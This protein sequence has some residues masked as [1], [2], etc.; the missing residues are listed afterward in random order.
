MHTK[1]KRYMNPTCRVSIE[2]VASLASIL[3]SSTDLKKFKLPT[4]ILWFWRGPN[5]FILLV[6]LQSAS[7][8]TCRLSACEGCSKKAIKCFDW[9]TN[10]QALGSA[11]RELASWWQLLKAATGVALGRSAYTLVMSC[12]TDSVQESKKTLMLCNLKF[13]AISTFLFHVKMK[14]HGFHKKV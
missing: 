5:L 7:L 14:P 8:S 9:K 13:W 2:I 3:A 6:T 11:H 4:F 12:D 10:D 1:K